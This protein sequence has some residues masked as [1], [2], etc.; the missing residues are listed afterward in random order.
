M[1]FPRYPK[2]KDSGVEWLGQ[3]P[4]H[5]QVCALKRIVRMQSGESITAEGIGESGEYPVFGGNGLRGYTS[6]FT[7]DGHYVLI[8]RQGALCGNINYGQGKFWASEH[9]VVV[10]PIKQVETIWLGEMMQAMNLNQYSATAA[11]PG[12][13]VDQVSRLE[14]IV[15]PLAEQT[16]IAAFLDQETAKIDELVA[17]QQRLMELLKEKRQAVISHAVTKG[18]DPKAPMKPSGIEWLGDVPENWE[19]ACLTRIAS[20][21][22]VG[23]AEAATHAYADEGIPIL[24]STNIR[25]GRIR[26]DILF[27]DPEFAGDRGSKQLNTGDL[28]TVRTGNAGVTAVIPPDFDGCQ[29]FTML[30]TTLNHGSSSEYYCYWMNSVSAQCY[31]SLEGWGTAQVNISVP[32]LKALPIPIPPTSEQKEIVEYLDREIG[33]FDTLTTETQRAIDLLQER[34]TALI[35]A[36][37]TGQIDVRKT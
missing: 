35:S 23:I 13:S 31:F 30:I 19:C 6:S 32:I 4:E 29:C 16:A 34:R 21:I 36:A 11:Q 5:W 28:V 10:A 20:R 18:L 14:T 22:V 2:Y 24:R 1:S 37:V 7:H 8:G 15:P 9:A 33:K 3:V 26:G 27:I 12:L 17:E 25:A